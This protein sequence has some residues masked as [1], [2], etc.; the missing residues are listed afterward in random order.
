MQGKV[1]VC[2]FNILPSS[3]VVRFIKMKIKLKCLPRDLEVVKSSLTAKLVYASLPS[4]PFSSLITDDD[5]IDTC[6][7]K[8]V[9]ARIPSCQVCL[10]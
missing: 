8:L 1:S 3:V 9:H 4:N 2:Y 10:L 7:I 5:V 6:K